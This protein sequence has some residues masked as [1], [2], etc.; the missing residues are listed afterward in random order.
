M[1]F[2]ATE[3]D[4]VNPHPSQRGGDLS[5]KGVGCRVAR[6]SDARIPEVAQV[7]SR[8]DVAAE[9]PQFR[10]GQVG[11]GHVASSSS[12]IATALNRGRATMSVVRG[13]PATTA[14]GSVSDQCTI[15]P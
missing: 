4:V 5:Y 15:H 13:E 11:P 2:S 9:R 1:A 7:G 10:E 8:L 12:I 6:R 3:L 14:Q